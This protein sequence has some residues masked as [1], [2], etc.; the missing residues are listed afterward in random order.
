MIIDEIQ[1]GAGRT[2][3]FFAIEHWGV[4]PDVIT[5]AKSFA[6]GMPLSAVIGRADLMNA[7]HVGGLGG[8]Y[9]GN[10][11]SCAAALAVMEILFEDNL[12]SKAKALGNV[13][14]ERFTKLADQFEIIGDVRGKGPMLGMELVKDRESKEPAVDE[15]KKLVQRCYD[16]GLI[17]LSCG[18]FGNVIRTLM[19]FVITDEELERGLAIL[20]E[21]FHELERS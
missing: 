1:A 18:N 6:G 14:W 15:A 4:E 10:P 8:T 12:L 5:L 16:K 2:G 21:S 11:V 13:L 7:P 17:I 20:E 19:P 3:T 9:G